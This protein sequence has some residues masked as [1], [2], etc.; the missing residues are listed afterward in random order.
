MRER[1]ALATAAPRPD[2]RFESR[3]TW[4]D[5]IRMHCRGTRQDPPDRPPVVLVH[6]MAVSHRYL[7]PLAACLA[8]HYPVRVVDLPGFGLSGGERARDLHELADGLAAWMEATGTAPAAVLA[9]SFGTQIAV[10]LAVTHPELV[11]SLILVGPTM[12][13]RAPSMLRQALRWVRGLP[14]EDPSQLPILVRDLLDAGLVR[15]WHTFHVALRDR[16]ER[17]LPH[18]RAPVLVTRGAKEAVASQRWVEEVVRLLPHG[19]SA[20]VPDSPHDATY[21]TP[22]ELAALVLPFLDRTSVEQPG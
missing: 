7:M 17:K 4:I 12:D 16:V 5:G 3:W 21:T 6:G 9:N 10:D 20:V 13:P 14:H 22:A 1:Y 15:A 19:E 18:V 2:A 11:R 8:D